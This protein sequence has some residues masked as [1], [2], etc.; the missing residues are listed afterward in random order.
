MEFGNR[1][2][3]MDFHYLLHTISGSE[4]DKVY[5][6]LWIYHCAEMQ[7]IQV[8]VIVINGMTY[9]MGLLSSW[10]CMIMFCI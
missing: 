10:Y 6:F 9:N 4:K 1:I 7:L 8:N 5:G 3:C 2:R